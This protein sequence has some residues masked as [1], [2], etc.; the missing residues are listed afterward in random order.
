MNDNP[1]EHCVPKSQMS[2]RQHHGERVSKATHI[3]ADEADLQRF[4]G[5]QVVHHPS[6][7]SLTIGRS[8][9]SYERQACQ[10]LPLFRIRRGYVLQNKLKIRRLYLRKNLNCAPT[11][12]LF[13]SSDFPRAL[14]MSAIARMPII[15]LRARFVT[16]AAC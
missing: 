4:I 10:C 3:L 15:P 8:Q 11:K 12:Y 7:G 16:L 1:L 6:R 5:V 13:A 14:L 9:V 2:L